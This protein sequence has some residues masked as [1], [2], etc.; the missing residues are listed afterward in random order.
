MDKVYSDATLVISA[1]RAMPDSSGFLNPRRNDEIIFIS[2]GEGGE[3]SAFYLQQALQ[4]LTPFADL[5]NSEPLHQRGWVLQERCLARRTLNFGSHR[6][7][8]ELPNPFKSEDGRLLLRPWFD[9][10]EVISE[11]KET[12]STTWASSEQLM[13]YRPRYKVIK[14]YMSCGLTYKSD[15]LPTIAGLSRIICML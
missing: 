12:P 9:P 11:T 13:L 8:L 14:I 5:L 7:I 3:M 10:Q 15:R 1:S 2:Y 6:V 4:P